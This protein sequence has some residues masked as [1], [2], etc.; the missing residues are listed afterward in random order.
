[1]NKK[2]LKALLVDHIQISL[3]EYKEEILDTVSI[4]ATETDEDGEQ[5]T[6]ELDVLE[7]LWD[8]VIESCFS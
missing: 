8:E 1:M 6:V 3:E 7:E 5:I 2:K 4:E